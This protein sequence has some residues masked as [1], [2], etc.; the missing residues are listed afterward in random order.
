MPPGG[1]LQRPREGLDRRRGY[2]VR[3]SSGGRGNRNQRL[4]EGR[5]VQG[6]QCG[7]GRC[8]DSGKSQNKAELLWDNGSL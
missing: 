8:D 3:S 4:L 1:F 6:A 7:E 2:F 5:A